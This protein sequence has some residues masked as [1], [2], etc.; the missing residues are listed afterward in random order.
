[1][2]I[3]QSLQER[4]ELLEKIDNKKVQCLIKQRMKENPSKRTINHWLFSSNK[5]NLQKI[6]EINAIMSKVREK[7]RDF[8]KTDSVE[9]ATNVLYKNLNKKLSYLD[10]TI[11]NYLCNDDES[12]AEP[13]D[14]SFSLKLIEIL[15]RNFG[16]YGCV[17]KNDF[18][19]I[20]SFKERAKA[21]TLNNRDFLYLKNHFS[22]QINLLNKNS[23]FKVGDI[24]YYSFKT[25]TTPCIIFE[26][27]K[28]ESGFVKIKLL[29]ND[30]I[31]ELVNFEI[32]SIKKTIRTKNAQ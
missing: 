3:D 19:I 11:I 16:W 6:N 10:S 12:L 27:A 17:R 21:G 8:T 13:N 32:N 29:M 20:L 15:D 31:V 7:N 23:T 28:L 4:I 26:P 9:I 18:F 24:A 1:M 14:V 5:I 30:S 2:I 25:E 22:S